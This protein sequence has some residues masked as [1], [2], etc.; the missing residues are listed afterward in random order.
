MSA[1]DI[2][3]FFEPSSLSTLISIGRPWQ[4]QPGTYGE[5]NPAM[6]LDL[7][8]KSFSDLVERVAEVDVAVGVGRAVVQDVLR[9]AGARV[10][11]LPVE[12]SCSQFSSIL[13]SFCGRLAF[14][15]KSVLGRLTV[16]L[17]S[18]SW[19]SM[20]SIFYGIKRAGSG[21][22]GFVGLRADLCRRCK[23]SG[24]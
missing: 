10:S 15:G 23:A 24:H 9:A 19:D 7:T 8:M 22:G 12:S 16:F 13:G 14:I 2:F 6:V 11:D 5:S 21:P 1:A 4:S 18:T 20:G 3:A 17:R